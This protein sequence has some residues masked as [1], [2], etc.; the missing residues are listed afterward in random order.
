MLVVAHGPSVSRPYVRPD[1]ARWPAAARLTVRSAVLSPLHVFISAGGPSLRP[2]FPFQSLLRLVPYHLRTRFLDSNS[3]R[4][5]PGCISSET[6]SDIGQRQAAN[7]VIDG[8]IPYRALRT[9]RRLN[10]QSAVSE[11]STPAS[12][13][14][15]QA[16]P[17]IDRQSAQ[18]RPR[19]RPCISASSRQQLPHRPQHASPLAARLPSPGVDLR[20]RVPRLTR[21]FGHS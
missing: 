2:L 8:E 19:V 4:E 16:S 15:L 21:P 13:K 11:A 7:H 18:G 10:Q 20:A 5:R 6:D 9:R 3:Q 17:D 14:R 12:D 1:L